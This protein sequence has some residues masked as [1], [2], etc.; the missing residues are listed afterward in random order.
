MFTVLG[1]PKEI[2]WYKEDHKT[3]EIA[4]LTDKV[5]DIFLPHI[6]ER[7]EKLRKYSTPLDLAYGVPFKLDKTTYVSSMP[8]SLL[9]YGTYISQEYSGK[10]VTREHCIELV[11]FA[12]DPSNCGVGSFHLIF[13]YNRKGLGVTLLW[14][15]EQYFKSR[16]RNYV[17]C[18]IN[19]TQKK[20]GVDKFLERH[21]YYKID[22]FIGGNSGQCCW[23]YVKDKSKHKPIDLD[24]DKLAKL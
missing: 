22:S 14:L 7:E 6:R 24:W 9:F 21:G 20:T 23:V 8:T 4:Y 18:T 10:T 5:K 3:G 16:G 12:T 15:V 11:R 13:N 2:G 1:D 19:T 17:H